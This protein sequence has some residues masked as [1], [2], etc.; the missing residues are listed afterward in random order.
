MKYKTLLIGLM[1]LVI[2]FQIFAT[3]K[4]FYYPNGE[5]ITKWVDE[6]IDGK[7]LKATF[8]H[9]T[10]EV[11]SV[12][13]F[14]NGKE[15]KVTYYYKAGEIKAVQEFVNGKE[16]KV[17]YYYKDSYCYYKTGEIKEVQ[18]FANGNLSKRTYYHKTGKINLVQEFANSNLSKTT[19]Y[20]KNE[21]KRSKYYISP[22]EDAELDKAMEAYY[23]SMNGAW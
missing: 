3:T 12:Q 22:A 17:T 6:Y 18:E 20:P 9:K 13:E 15:S 7:I 14:V 11:D 16:S 19:H 21:D 5:T 4:T 8:Y 1:T 23:A 10:G 2:S